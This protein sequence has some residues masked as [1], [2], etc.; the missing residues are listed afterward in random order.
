LT[1]AYGLSSD[2][3][4]EPGLLQHLEAGAAEA[5]ESPV[6]S[7]SSAM[8]RGATFALSGKRGG[9]RRD[10]KDMIRRALSAAVGVVVLAMAASAAA[11]V[12][13]VTTTVSLAEVSDSDSFARALEQVVDKARAETIAFEPSVV[14]VTGVRVLGERVL[15]SLLFADADG[16]AMLETLQGRRGGTG[17]PDP[18]A[19]DTSGDLR[20]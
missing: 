14:A 5:T 6:F 3:I 8:P 13:E 9:R 2:G 17:G 20:I 7:G 15:I 16:E 4:P 18:G 1:G 10:V 19:P 12:A 11:H